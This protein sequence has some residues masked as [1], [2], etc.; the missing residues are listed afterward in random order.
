MF[1]VHPDH[2]HVAAAAAETHPEAKSEKE[3]VAVSAGNINI[4]ECEHGF[5]AVLSEHHLMKGN[6]DPI[7]SM[8]MHH[9][10]G[11][12]KSME[13]HHEA[14]AMPVG[15]DYGMQVE[16]KQEA[17]TGGISTGKSEGL[18]RSSTGVFWVKE[19]KSCNV[20]S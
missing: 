18:Q 9:E 1:L 11:A 19:G 2:L 8:E 3:A 20:P 17:P 13:M 16:H 7:K 5:N 15:T 14:G 4:S 12:I 10:A 6:S